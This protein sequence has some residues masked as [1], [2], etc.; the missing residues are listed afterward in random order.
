MTIETILLMLESVLLVVTVL[1]LIYSLRE[2]KSRKN[3]LLEVGKTTKMLTRQEY[4]LTVTDSMADA[5]IEI[6]GFI[7]GRLP[8]ADDK[9]RVRDIVNIIEKSIKRGVK[10]KYVVPKFHDRLHIGSL[11]SRAGAEVRYGICASNIRFIILDDQFVVIGIPESTG[12][13]EATKKGYR[14]PS[15]GLAEILKDHFYKCWEESMPFEQY[16]KDQINLTGL[17]PKR[18][19]REIQVDETEIARLARE[20]NQTK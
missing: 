4:F 5:S 14:I 17:T 15:E 19:G 10:V 16:V 7:T 2:G 11:Y 8:L 6:I 12:K 1:L 18:L 9:K 13:K 3:L 20:K